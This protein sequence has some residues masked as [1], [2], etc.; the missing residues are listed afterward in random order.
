MRYFIL[1]SSSWVPRFAASLACAASL[2]CSAWGGVVRSPPQCP[3]DL[4]GDG[5]VD[6]HDLQ[7][8]LLNYG[9]AVPPGSSGDM[10]QDGFVNTLDLVAFLRRFG[11]TCA[12]ELRFRWDGELIEFGGHQLTQSFTRP[13]PSSLPGGGGNVE[14][15]VP[16]YW[17]ADRLLCGLPNPSSM[18]LDGQP[19]VYN[20][21][22]AGG[23]SSDSVSPL[24]IGFAADPLWVDLIRL[25]DA[26]HTWRTY[27]F[28]SSNT[29][30]DLLHGAPG[31]LSTDPR[32]WERN[33]NICH[34][35]IISV[36][37]VQEI[38][39]QLGSNWIPTS[40]G[41]CYADEA[42]ATASK[43][44]PWNLH[45]RQPLPYLDPGEPRGASFACQEFRT[46]DTGDV[47]TAWFGFTDY[48]H[49]STSPAQ[50]PMNANAYIVRA[51]RTTV[52]SP[53]ILGA[54]QRV[55]SY[56]LSDRPQVGMHAHPPTIERYGERGLCVVC[57]FG[58]S[59]GNNRV[60]AVYRD[61]E[62]TY[63]QGEA[64][65][66][67]AGSQNGWTTRIVHGSPGALPPAYDKYSGGEANQFV[68]SAPL[69]SIGQQLIG[70]DEMLVP[71]MK[72]TLPAEEAQREGSN[73]KFNFVRLWGQPAGGAVHTDD[74]ATTLRVWNTF[75][76]ARKGNRSGPYA[77]MISPGY[78]WQP[79]PDAARLLFSPDGE[80]WAPFF[81]CRN[82]SAADPVAIAG[83]TIYCA[84]VN[85]LRPTG[86]GN[87]PSVKP[88]ACR[89]W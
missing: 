73:A 34:G 74:Y 55:L 83:D 80:H 57:P 51:S 58:D 67:D 65:S 61:D 37:Q 4:N 23:V 84:F 59:R 88:S 81:A 78:N 39:T 36:A 76:F 85:S 7:L 89:A 25:G 75:R 5:V 53:W 15:D 22:L 47:L 82:S 70:G 79:S 42:S 46:F 6:T 72:L 43:P 29:P 10:I 35:L 62:S 9:E 26:A 13:Y 49:C 86:P 48:N 56:S 2:V 32:P 31:H 66:L 68:G 50:S 16:R 11:D 33:Y 60:V 12:T 87:E 30:G 1:P 63:A 41:L 19:G 28:V 77:A 64:S 44:L 17:L 38:S 54:V 3:G 24:L 8:L 14:I 20:V 27:G 52:G 69:P 18:P 45:W 40:I 21:P 71:I